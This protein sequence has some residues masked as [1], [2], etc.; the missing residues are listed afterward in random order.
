MHR[1]V[2]PL[3]PAGAGLIWRSPTREDAEA[4]VR[5]TKRVDRA[6]RLE[7]VDGPSFFRW[8]MTQ[9]DF[10]PETD[11]LVGIDTVGE[12]AVEAGA[13]TQVTDSGG[14]AFLWFGAVPGYEQHKPYLLS[15]A[16]SFG[17]RGLASVPDGLDRVLRCPVEEHR[18]AHRAV[19]EAAGFEAVRSF[20]AMER[21]L[22]SL[23]E[24]GSIPDG[25]DIIPWSDEHNEQARQ[26][27]N[28]A[29]ADHWGSLPMTADAW[30]DMY[31]RSDQFRPDL[32]YL[33]VADDRVIGF[34][35]VEID[36]ENNQD[37]GIREIYINKVGTIRDRR[38]RGIAT[39][40]LERSLMSAAAIGM[41]RAALNV[42]ENSYTKATEVYRRIGF[43]VTMRSIHYVK[44]L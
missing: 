16:E 24:P 15:V 25:I 31:A 20:V 8:L 5:H 28:D 7:Y 33:A 43:E 38:R 21:S 19:I 29:F 2:T 30:G 4:L 6:E 14:R 34:C 1:P 32:S 23:P 11:W 9:H 44:N 17:R 35:V 39:H 36:E 18:T 13:W 3:P 41:E 10:D 42:D 40:L 27:N 12:V 37:R 26:A 22:S